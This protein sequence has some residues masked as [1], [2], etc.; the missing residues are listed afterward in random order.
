MAKKTK[1]SDAMKRAL[2]AA[3]CGDGVVRGRG[4]L[5]QSA[6][7]LGYAS[8]VNGKITAAGRKVAADE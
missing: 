8:P 7:R 2:K 6:Q 1:I 3:I 4:R 5:A